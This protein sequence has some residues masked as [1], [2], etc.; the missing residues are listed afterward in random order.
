METKCSRQQQKIHTSTTL[1]LSFFSVLMWVWLLCVVFFSLTVIWIQPFPNW[2]LYI[3]YV[4]IKLRDN[5]VGYWWNIHFEVN[6]N[7]ATKCGQNQ[8]MNLRW[9]FHTKMSIGLNENKKLH[10]IKWKID[11]E[12]ERKGEREG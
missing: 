8:Y 3:V 10:H 12:R 7:D 6:E 2:S 1:S 4:S 9:I 5:T 11:R